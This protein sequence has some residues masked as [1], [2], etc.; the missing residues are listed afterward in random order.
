MGEGAV[1]NA[2]QQSSGVIDFN[3]DGK[4]DQI[5]WLWK[6][7]SRAFSSY[8]DPTV[9]VA[10]LGTANKDQYIDLRTVR[11]LTAC[12]QKLKIG[13]IIKDDPKESDRPIN[14]IVTGFFVKAKQETNKI[15][16][17]VDYGLRLYAQLEPEIPDGSHRKS[18]RTLCGP[19]FDSTLF[20]DDP[21]KSKGAQEAAYSTMP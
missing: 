17:R 12:G 18:T 20:A 5:Q 6:V 7:V 4:P 3:G 2:T 19:F 11:G 9:T 14:R 16:G 13:D 8:S 21:D 1:K 15:S 10:K